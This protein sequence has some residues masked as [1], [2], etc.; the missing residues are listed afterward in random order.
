MTKPTR[1]YEL[2]NQEQYDQVLAEM[3]TEFKAMPRNKELKQA[4]F[5]AM[6]KKLRA[7]FPHV[8]CDVSVDT[9]DPEHPKITLKQRI[10]PNY[11]HSIDRYNVS[12]KYHDMLDMLC[13]KYGNKLG[14]FLTNRLA[15]MIR[16]RKAECIDNLR[17]A[18]VGYTSSMLEYNR[19]LADGCCG[20]ADEEFVFARRVGPLCF[21]STWKI[22]F[23]Y[24]H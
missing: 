19:Q 20:F 16:V 22:G 3:R 1:T 11:S 17:I 7:R 5:L 15:K 2:I 12:D 18:R 6:S 13:K 8:R 4:L 10:H 23:N 9:T 24:G 14:C 21:K